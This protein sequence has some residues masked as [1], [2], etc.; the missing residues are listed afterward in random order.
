M[1]VSNHGGSGAKNPGSGWF[2]AGLLSPMLLILNAALLFGVIRAGGDGA[3][4]AR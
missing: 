2:S 3:E 1:G 4:P